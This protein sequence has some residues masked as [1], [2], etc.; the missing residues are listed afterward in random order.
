MDAAGALEEH[1]LIEAM[2]VKAGG[3]DEMAVLKSLHLDWQCQWYR[4]CEG[5][6][7]M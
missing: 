5:Q 4:R 2:A 7:G 1:D 3:L 6:D